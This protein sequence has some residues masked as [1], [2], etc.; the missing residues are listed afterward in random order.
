MRRLVCAILLLAGLSPIAAWPC[1]VCNTPTGDQVREGIFN[2]HFV[3]NAVIVLAPFPIFAAGVAWI[4]F[5][6]SSAR[7]EEHF[8]ETGS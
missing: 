3:R 1:P 2:R 7:K 6:G 5:G 4:Y 8:N